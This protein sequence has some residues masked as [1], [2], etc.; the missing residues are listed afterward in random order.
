MTGYLAAGLVAVLG[1]PLIQVHIILFCEKVFEVDEFKFGL[2]MSTYGIG[3]ITIAPWLAAFGTKFK[4]SNLLIGSLALY[5]CGELLLS[6]TK[7]YAIGLLSIFIVGCAHLV[8][9]TTTNT[10]LQLFV[11]EP[12]RGRVMAMYLMVFTIGA[13]LGSII[14][15]PL[16]DQ[17]GPRWVVAIMGSL[18]LTAAMLFAVS[19]RAATFNFDET[20]N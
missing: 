15:G 3:A 7:E 8:M 19:G 17:F 11:P 1:A 18:F 2:L 10:T 13:P 12:V 9:A 20:D 4:K 6:S 14:Q 16:A 5:G